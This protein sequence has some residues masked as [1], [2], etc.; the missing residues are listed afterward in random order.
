M[1]NDNQYSTFHSH[2]YSTIEYNNETFIEIV[3]ADEDPIEIQNT[4]DRVEL[5]TKL[6]NQQNNDSE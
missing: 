4:I 2:D 3:I 6:L 1:T 5:I